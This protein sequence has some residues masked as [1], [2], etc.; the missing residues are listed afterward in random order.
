[1]RNL[2]TIRR[3]RNTVLEICEDLEQGKIFLEDFPI[4]LIKRLKHI[5]ETKK[6]SIAQ[7]IAKPRD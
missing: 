7:S 4:D 5:L 3:A 2:E 1:M 6:C